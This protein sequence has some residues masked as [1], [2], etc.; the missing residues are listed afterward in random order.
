MSATAKQFPK[1]LPQIHGQG[2]HRYSE[3]ERKRRWC[4]IIE[5]IL[6]DPG[7]PS[8]ATS[9]HREHSKGKPHRKS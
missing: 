7:P 4:L 5:A 3:A 1:S 6:V 2:Q 9:G 8:P